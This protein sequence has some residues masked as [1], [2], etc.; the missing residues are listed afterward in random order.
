MENPVRTARYRAVIAERQATLATRFA[1]IFAD[2]AEFVWE[3]GCGHGHFLTAYANDHRDRLCI[4]IDISTERI[5]RATRKL[6]RSQ[7]P[8][9][10]FIQAEARAFLETLPPHVRIADLFVLFPDPWPKS[11]HRKHRILQSDFLRR[12]AERSTPDARFFFRTDHEPYFAE[13]TAILGPDIGWQRSEEA[14]P[15]EFETVFQSRAESFHSLTAHRIT[16]P[17]N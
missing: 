5:E 16:T 11:R 1:G 3:I 4:G 15:Y 17:K 10:H 2:H 7:L 9:L 6:K 13:V 8:N 12:V 14:W